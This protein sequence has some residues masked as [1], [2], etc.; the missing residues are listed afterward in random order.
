MSKITP[1]A[2]EPAIP[3]TEAERVAADLKQAV[4]EGV[5]NKAR[6]Y[7]A[8]SQATAERL[9]IEERAIV[10]T[11]NEIDAKIAALNEERADAMVAYGAIR[12]ARETLTGGAN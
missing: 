1:A 3:T 5:A 12:A 6:A 7:T 8:H 9:F 2:S 11:L 4:A 10:E